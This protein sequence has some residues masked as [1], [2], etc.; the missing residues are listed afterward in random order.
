M[1][2]VLMINGNQ[3]KPMDQY[4]EDREKE[5]RKNLLFNYGLLKVFMSFH[6]R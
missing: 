3:S 5:K 1:K 6:L 2:M 4:N